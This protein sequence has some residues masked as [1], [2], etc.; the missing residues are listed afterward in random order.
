MNEL[1]QLLERWRLSIPNNSNAHAPKV[2]KDYSIEGDHVFLTITI[3]HDVLNEHMSY[4]MN[5]QNDKE[6]VTKLITLLETAKEGFLDS[7]L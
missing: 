6:N 2:V 7:L 5:C 3:D 1:Q 4:H